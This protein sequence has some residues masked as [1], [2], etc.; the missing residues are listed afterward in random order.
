MAL[1]V[2][3]DGRDATNDAEGL[4]FSNTD[5]GGFESFSATLTGPYLTLPKGARILVTDGAE[6]IW[7][8]RVT[9]VEQTTARGR[10]QVRVAG[11]GYRATLAEQG[12][13]MIY[14]DRS[15][16]AWTGA[17]SL[18]RQI[19]YLPSGNGGINFQTPS[20]TPDGSKPAVM[21]RLDR[22]TTQ[23]T[24][25][26]KQDRSEGWYDAG[27]NNLIGKVYYDIDTADRAASSG[28]TQSQLSGNW[29]IY[30]SLTND[31]LTGTGGASTG[32]VS[33][34]TPVQNTLTATTD[35]RYAYMR[36]YYGATFS[37]D[38]LWRAW[39]R[40]P[41]V[42]GNHN[43]PLRGTA[44][45]GLYPSDIAKHALTQLPTGSVRV[46]PDASIPNST[47]YIL[48][49]SVYRDWTPIEQ[50]ITDMAGV[51]GW[52]WGVWE[53]APLD[54]QP[55]LMFQPPPSYATATVDA[56]ACEPISVV[57]RLE[58]LFNRAVITYT[59]AAGYAQRLTRSRVVPEL[60]A[61]NMIRT[62]NLTIGTS[63]ATAATS[64]ADY[65]LVLSQDQAR[66]GG[67]AT[68]PLAVMDASGAPRQSYTLR[69]GRDKL[70]IGGLSNLRS[71][72][73][74][75]ET[76][77]VF[78]IKRSETTVERGGL[79]RTRIEFDGGTNLTD[80]LQARLAVVAN[81]A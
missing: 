7:D 6:T 54:D 79:I 21:F 72:G 74:M 62:L 67:S 37:G 35:C 30:L 33:G 15:L 47:A 1:L 22:L 12:Y 65:M 58:G 49:H 50:V 32:D 40:N 36:L 3:I 34:T 41:A 43:L 13:S 69:A 48:P 8:G 70:R 42:Y 66:G 63:T 52:H 4:T 9:E 45:K 57:D 81:I 46:T 25:P 78:R 2:Q 31:T 10:T 71:A 53:P 16:S 56:T 60:D 14:V 24:A 20:I 64:L 51:L 29:S 77:D 44:P 73:P 39:L 68:L 61:Y 26:V 55:R 27:P 80:V 18:A 19:K 38:G 28:T 5:P 59:D 11:Q 75:S 23:T 76:Q 17:P